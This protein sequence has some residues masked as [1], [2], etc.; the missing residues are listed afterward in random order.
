MSDWKPIETAPRDG[1]DILVFHKVHGPMAA[2]FIAGE[3]S[4]HHEY[5]RQY[6]GP[7]WCFGDDQFQ[8]EVEEEGH[9]FHDGSVTHWMPLPEPPKV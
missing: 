2:R 6:D 1:T 5:G 7:F 9:K 3:W 4:E 8:E